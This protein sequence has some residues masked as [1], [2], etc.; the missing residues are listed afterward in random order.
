MPFII[1]PVKGGYKVKKDVKGG[2]YYSKKPLPKPIAEAQRRAIYMH[3]KD[4]KR[5]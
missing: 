3:E 1:V 2:E 4:K 5:Q